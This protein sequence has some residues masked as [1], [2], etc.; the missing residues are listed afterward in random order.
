MQKKGIAAESIRFRDEGGRV[1]YLDHKVELYQGIEAFLAKNL[2][3]AT[4]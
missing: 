4:P 2:G 3:A 1:R